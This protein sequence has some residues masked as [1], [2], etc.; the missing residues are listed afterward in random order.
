MV[1]APIYANLF[2]RK[3]AERLGTTSVVPFKQIDGKR[4]PL[5]VYVPVS[6]N[7]NLNPSQPVFRMSRFRNGVHL[8]NGCDLP[9]GL[10]ERR[11]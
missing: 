4:I 10:R 3:T 1:P 9:K 6:R 7:G 8:K 5:P 11:F 2:S